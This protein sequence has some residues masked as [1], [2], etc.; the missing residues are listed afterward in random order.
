MHLK[1]LLVISC[2]IVFSC[3]QEKEQDNGVK[4]DNVVEHEEVN[5][6]QQETAEMVR[7]LA[8]LNLNGQPQ[9][10][11]HWNGRKA[12]ML[13]DQI[14]GG[15]HPYHG[16]VWYEY[17]TQ[18]LRAGD[19]E[20][21]ITE[22]E[23]HFDPDR[24]YA[25]QMSPKNYLLFELLALAYLRL[26]EQQNCQNNHT[27]FSCILPLNE[28]AFHELRE[29]SE[30]ALSLYKSMFSK[31]PTDEYK[32]LINI[33][34]MTLG[35][36]QNE[37]PEVYRLN[38]PNWKIEQQNFPR[39][40]EVAM[41]TNVAQNGLSGGTCLDD[42]NND[43]YQDIFATAY[44]MDEQAALF[45]NT[46]EG[47]FE[48]KTEA[49]LIQGIV[50][51]LN[52]VHADY[53]N[54]GNIDILV[55]RGAWLNVNGNHPNS[56]LKNNGDGTFSDVTKSAGILSYHP[57]QTAGWADFNKDGFLDLFIGNE[58][59]SGFSNP[60][61]LYQNNGDG[62]FT[63]VSQSSG[64]GSIVKFVKGVAWGDINNDQWPDLFI[65]VSGG[66]NLM[67]K[68]VEGTFEEI[69]ETSGTTDPLYSFPCWF[70]DVNNDGYQDLFVAGYDTRH[71]DDV[72]DIY[73]KE[74]Q[75]IPSDIS[76][77]RL[78]INNG[79][80]T[81]S[82]QTKAYGLYKSMFAMG[83]NFGDLDNDGYLDFYIGT[84]SPNFTAIVPNRMFR[85]VRG[86]KFEEVTS[87]GGFGHIQKGHGIAFSDFDRD[88]DQ[89]VYAVMG[90]AFEGDNFTNVLFE[91]PGFDN[92][93]IVI[94]LEG[95]STNRSAIGTYIELTLNNGKK[96]YRTIGTGSSFGSNSLQEE[97]GLGKA[98]QISELIIHWQNGPVETFN[99]IE[100]N[101]KIKIKENSGEVE[102]KKYDYVPFST[103]PGSHMHNH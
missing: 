98:T 32:W 29:G 34:Y 79:D 1:Q 58:S 76:L 20:K 5:Q 30:K 38:F 46:G 23:G 26:G 102:T 97:I 42:F 60:C 84:G 66:K 14:A 68:N 86:K 89:D 35:N 52:C 59:G 47:I 51:G 18:L 12:E 13:A 96:F 31:V 44:G 15:Q 9:N 72:A 61:E 39:F 77:P 40:K 94:E 70:W 2:L 82:D 25:L 37:I 8:N 6:A 19:T 45:L 90:G 54:D 53:D 56:L 17:C 95:T 57:T 67:F 27:E 48:N 65:S 43:G 22:L 33:A 92:N 4:T 36:E 88:G 100:V 11:L 50:S 87:A 74:L 73:A 93:W 21:C 16:Q 80:E 7:I 55:L 81:F 10:Y 63:E 3:G 99:A 69:S 85:N 91:N 83:S 28:P 62:T 75:G 103:E 41:N 78:F 71:F 49:S 64:L 101:Q 24:P